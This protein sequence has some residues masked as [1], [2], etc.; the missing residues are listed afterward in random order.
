LLSA[1]D[2]VKRGEFGDWLI[3]AVIND[4]ELTRIESA[5]SNYVAY[6]YL[7]AF[8]NN[9]SW[10][11]YLE[12]IDK[13]AAITKEEV[14]AFANERYTDHV[15]VYKRVGVDTTIAKVSNPAITPL[16]INRV[17]ESSFMKE[18][19]EVTILGLDPVFVDFNTAIQQSSLNSGIELN[20]IENTTNELFNLNYILDMG[21]E[22]NKKLSLAVQYL[23]YL[24]TD[25]YTASELQE[26]FYKLG[27]RMSVSASSN[28]S[29]V[30]IEGLEKSAD[31]GVKLLEHILN[32]VKAD[33]EAYNDYVD[34]IIK[35][36]ADTKLNKRNIMFGGMRSYGIY[37]PQ[38]AFTDIIPEE[39]L[40]AQEPEELVE[41]IKGL[42]DYEHYLFYY[43]HES[44]AEAVDMINR[45]HKVNKE[46][47]PYPTPSTKYEPLDTDQNLVYFV[48]YD[49]VQ[50]EIMLLAKDEK[51]NSAL[52]PYAKLYGSY[53]GSGLSSIMFQEIREA[54]GLAYTA[55]SSFSTPALPDRHHY[56]T[57]YVGTQV[58]KLSE[59]VPAMMAIINDMPESEKMFDASKKSI[60]KKIE[61]E[62]L[63]KT[64][65][66]WSYLANKRRG[67]NHDVRQNIYE[68]V[69]TLNMSDLRGFIETHIKKDHYVYLVIG[70]RDDID[71]EFLETLGEYRELTLE[72]IFGY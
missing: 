26:E 7:D 41:I 56:M 25:K 2:K 64:S 33:Q 32:N 37:G 43:G 60:L 61:T 11:D 22:H 27:L 15:V 38:S 40:K 29:Y 44:M 52:M 45:H 23:P 47:L 50:T 59:A 8:I 66:F 46:L 6:E 53:F 62:R 57:A 69:Q 55:R 39:D 12:R 1:L 4:I 68:K 35:K 20:Y 34:G 19:K 18:F 72:D 42:F 14:V 21:K 63:T 16:S 51:F 70:S 71:K 67:I 31:A 17:D 54:K 24:G 28:R 48:N 13:I 10:V 30:S 36:R 9:V 3:P 65:I 5:A 58:N 49:M